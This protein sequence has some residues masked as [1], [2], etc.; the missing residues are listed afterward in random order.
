MSTPF[1]PGANP[2]NRD[3][4]SIGNWAEADEGN[5][6]VLVEGLDTDGQKNRVVYT[7]FDLRQ[8]QEYRSYKKRSEFDKRFSKSGW[9]WHDK[10]PFPWQKIAD[11]GVRHPNAEPPEKA[12][13][14]QPP[15]KAEQ[16]AREEGATPEP[17]REEPTFRDRVQGMASK[18]KGMLRR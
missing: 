6:L 5:S 3:K 7:L 13:E 12:A 17:L 15:S 9:T 18:F 8:G 4:L 14:A 1:V 11:A 16:T 2:A 10:T